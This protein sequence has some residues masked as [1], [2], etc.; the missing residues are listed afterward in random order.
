MEKEKIE[1]NKKA[2]ELEQVKVSIEKVS[3][4]T[5]WFQFRVIVII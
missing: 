1:R 5:K 4:S 3:N 2:K